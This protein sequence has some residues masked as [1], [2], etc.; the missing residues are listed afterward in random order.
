[1]SDLFDS[2]WARPEFSQAHLTL[3]ALLLALS[4]AWQTAISPHRRR[5]MGV[6]RFALATAIVSG[7]PLAGVIVIR[8]AFRHA[9]IDAGHS[10]WGAL[11]LSFAWMLIFIAAARMLVKRVPPTSWLMAD[12]KLANSEGWRAFLGMSPRTVRRA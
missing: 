9:F 11:W 5:A 4:V 6:S 10:W 1:M 12:L 7:I 3:F 2:W 8:A